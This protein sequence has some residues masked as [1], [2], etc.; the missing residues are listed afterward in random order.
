M[1]SPA[2]IVLVHNADKILLVRSNTFCG[3]YY[4]LVAGFVELGESVEEAVEREI[5]EETN[6][7]VQRIKYCGSQAWPFPD[8]LMLAFTA[9]YKSGEIKIQESE[10]LEAQWFKRTELPPESQLPRPGSVA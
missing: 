2:I 8:Q 1:L 5:K 6:I 4:G 3:E 10:I 7:E 9:E